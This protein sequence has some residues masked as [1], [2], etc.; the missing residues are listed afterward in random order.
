MLI[1]TFA[2]SDH[3]ALVNIRLSLVS[4]LA[5]NLTLLIAR[6]QQ[7]ISPKNMTTGVHL[8]GILW[9]AAIYSIVISF[10]NIHFRPRMLLIIGV[11]FCLGLEIIVS[12]ILGACLGDW[13]AS[14][15]YPC[16]GGEQTP[17][18]YWCVIV[19]IVSLLLPMILFLTAALRGV[20]V[21]SKLW[22]GWTSG[23]AGGSLFAL[24]VINEVLIHFKGYDK[25]YS[26]ESMQWGLGQTVVMVSVA[27]QLLE[28]FS[29]LQQPR[30]DSNYNCKFETVP[31]TA[32]RVIIRYV[33]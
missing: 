14:P 22:W 20:I 4:S 32:R 29:Y 31:T 30:G 25:G 33:E 2:A 12:C 7:C 18:T 27:G 23:I 13:H 9:T 6:I 3:F 15:P 26:S 24:I 8:G 16:T 19:G 11:L 5:I 1:A 10:R 28:L 21:R 17:S